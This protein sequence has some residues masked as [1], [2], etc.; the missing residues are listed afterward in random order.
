MAPKGAEGTA[1][2]GELF[3]GPEAPHP[4]P[5]PPPAVEPRAVALRATAPAP[6][7]EAEGRQLALA[8]ADQPR[9]LSGAC[10]LNLDCVSCNSAWPH[11]AWCGTSATCH[12]TTPELVRLGSQAQHVVYSQ[13]EYMRTYGASTVDGTSSSTCAI[14]II[15]RDSCSWVDGY[16]Q[17]FMA[18]TCPECKQLGGC[19]YCFSGGLTRSGCYSGSLSGPLRVQQSDAGCAGPDTWVF[20][21]WSR[22]YT[23]NVWDPSCWETCRP[24]EGRFTARHGVFGMGDRSAQVY[25]A[26][27]S[28]CSWEIAPQDWGSGQL[29]EVIMEFSSLA[30]RGDMLRLSKSAPSHGISG[31]WRV[32]EMLGAVGCV[33]SAVSCIAQRSVLTDGPAA[34]SFVSAQRSKHSSGGVWS[35]RWRLVDGVEDGIPIRSFVWM[36]LAM[37]LVPMLAVLLWVVWCRRRSR[38]HVATFGSSIEREGM[39]TSIEAVDIGTL[40]RQYPRC[41]PRIVGDPVSARAGNEGPE[42]VHESNEI[43]SEPAAN[44]EGDSQSTPTCSVCLH[45]LVAGE[46][47][48][49]LPCEHVFHR[50]CIDAWF[51]RSNKCPLCRSLVMAPSR[52]QAALAPATS[53]PGP[54][55]PPDPPA[56]AQLPPTRL[57]GLPRTWA[58]GGRPSGRAARASGAVEI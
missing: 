4:D 3:E 36:G 41:K 34:I 38:R 5:E 57:Y 44:N 31:Q 25:Y 6:T 12:D 24:Y 21:N 7:P 43:S 42:A 52:Q 2:R 37:I 55:S 16:C 20:G 46:E 10:S 29:L 54:Q 19:G 1:W 48:R 18:T 40:E 27:N 56:G 14:W 35:V 53:A 28:D 17:K 49:G 11:C 45:E 51:G 22:Y 23:G 58:S 50:C 30:A 47:V 32:G 39:Q 33:D 26:A 8:G 9:R 15:N 13:Q